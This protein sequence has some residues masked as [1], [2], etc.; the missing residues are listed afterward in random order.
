MTTLTLNEQVL[1]LSYQAM[2][3]QRFPE[4][5]QPEVRRIWETEV[6]DGYEVAGLTEQEMLA[7]GRFVGVEFYN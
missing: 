3:E 4:H 5:L 6:T 2:V 1:R 7:L